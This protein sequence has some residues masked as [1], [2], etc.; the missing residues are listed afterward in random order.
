MDSALCL[1]RRQEAPPWRTD[2]DIWRRL[3]GQIRWLKE[4]GQTFCISLL[5][6]PG[7]WL[8][9]PWKSK[10]MS[11]EHGKQIETKIG[12]AFSLHAN[13]SCSTVPSWSAV[14]TMIW[15]EGSQVAFTRHRIRNIGQGF[16]PQPLSVSP[17]TSNTQGQPWSHRFHL[18]PGGQAT[19]KIEHGFS[20]PGQVRM[21]LATVSMRKLAKQKDW[22]RV[23]CQRKYAG[24]WLI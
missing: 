16:L 7:P 20:G 4:C 6:N 11:H 13:S 5:I 9:P 3:R 21:G 18:C 19:K 22:A 15:R 17:N 10:P 23:K 12:K 2:G 14:L 8:R 1:W 24:K